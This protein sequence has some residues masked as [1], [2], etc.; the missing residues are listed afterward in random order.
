MPTRSVK[1]TCSSQSRPC[2]R[3]VD[4]LRAQLQLGNDQEAVDPTP[5]SSPNQAAELQE[6]HNLV[7]RLQGGLQLNAC[8]MPYLLACNSMCLPYINAQRHQQHSELAWPGV[9]AYGSSNLLRPLRPAIHELAAGSSLACAPHTQ[10][11]SGAGQLA[12]AEHAAQDAEH[13]ARD[14]RAM[15]AKNE[16][17]LEGLSDAYNALEAAN[18]QLE[19]QVQQQR[20]SGK[21]LTGHLPAEASSCTVLRWGVLHVWLFLEPRWFGQLHHYGCRAPV[22]C[23]MQ[24]EL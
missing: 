14:A 12:S 7:Q 4:D 6:L 24:E 2:C 13:E 18:T 10:R 3:E 9:W 17:D 22:P 11:V 16:A 23:A 20:A 5:G 15:L 1:P 19:S 8:S 21:W